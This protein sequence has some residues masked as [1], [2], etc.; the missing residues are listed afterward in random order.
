ML[1]FC[2]LFFSRNAS[3]SLCKKIR[4]TIIWTHP[5]KLVSIHWRLFVHLKNEESSTFATY[6]KI[7][8]PKFGPNHAYKKWI[9]RGKIEIK[10]KKR[11]FKNQ[12][13]FDLKP[14]DFAFSN[15]PCWIAMRWSLFLFVCFMISSFKNYC[16][17][18]CVICPK[19]RF[20]DVLPYY[21][22]PIFYLP[23][24]YSP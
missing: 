21:F 11:I 22:L 17:F 6:F 7:I 20:Q 18:L 23:C 14:R 15:V 2:L 12:H 24:R 13:M 3:E 9:K 8:G 5:K 10:K 16:P 1:I 4:S 19:I